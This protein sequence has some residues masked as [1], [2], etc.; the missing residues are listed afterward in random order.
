[1]AVMCLRL[2]DWLYFVRWLWLRACGCMAGADCDVAT[3][4]GGSIDDWATWAVG[5]P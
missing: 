4:G 1:M 5:L 3:T 2:L